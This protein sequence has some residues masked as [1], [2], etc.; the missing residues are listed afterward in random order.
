MMQKYRIVITMSRYV[1]S[2]ISRQEICHLQPRMPN[3]SKGLT[4]CFVISLTVWPMAPIRS[5]GLS[6]FSLRFFSLGCL[7][8]CFLSR[9][10][11]PVGC[12]W[13]DWVAVG[14]GW[15]VVVVEGFVIDAV[16]AALYVVVLVG[17]VEVF[18]W[19]SILRWTFLIH[20]T[21]HFTLEN[22]PGRFLRQSS[23][24]FSSSV[25]V[26]FKLSTLWNL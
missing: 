19:L 9:G 6:L 5:G 22:T 18:D 7:F 23:V 4:K 24:E 26:N 3:I 15:G 25:L 20:P 17:F 16:S 12:V 21:K 2:F 13:R 8:G 11:L 14:C 1:L 10:C